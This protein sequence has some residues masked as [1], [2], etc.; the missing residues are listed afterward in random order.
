[1][2]IPI[3][4]WD[5]FWDDGYCPDGEVVKTHAYVENYSMDEELKERAMECFYNYLKTLD[6][7]NEVTIRLSGDR[8]YFVNISHKILDNLMA[9]LDLVELV[10]DDNVLSIY[11]ES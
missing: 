5:D 1:M 3:N 9:Y 2:K 6:F 10:V 8:I 4:I 7:M 11:S